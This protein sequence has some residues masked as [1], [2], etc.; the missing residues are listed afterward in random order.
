MWYLLLALLAMLPTASGVNAQGL[1]HKGVSILLYDN[2]SD[3]SSKSDALLSHL[4]ELGINSV[5]LNFSIFQDGKNATR[6]YTNGRTP[7]DDNLRTI[8]RQAHERGFRVMLRP[9]MDQSGLEKG[10]WRGS[11]EPS[12]PKS[13]FESYT[14]LVLHY[15]DL[16]Q[17]NGVEYLSIGTELNSMEKYSAEWEL[18]IEQVRKAYTGTLIYSFNWDSFLLTN[19]PFASKLVDAK[20]ERHPT[21]DA[22]FEFRSAPS[23]ITN[24]D[25]LVPYWK[26]W[27]RRI[28]DEVTGEELLHNVIFA[29]IGVTPFKD[30]YHTPWMAPP[31]PRVFDENMQS[32]YITAACRAVGDEIEGIYFWMFEVGPNPNS[33]GSH[34]NLYGTKAEQAIKDCFS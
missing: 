24:P 15:A 30:A 29:E 12:D 22:Y 21:V 2:P 28:R 17:Q 1:T 8:I 7:T 20:G 27:L 9:L 14:K 26:E 32:M 6:V 33:R 13:W 16:S 4:K 19:P 25:Q 5:Q 11:I 10:Q 34:F 18:L 3:F 23:G 31:E